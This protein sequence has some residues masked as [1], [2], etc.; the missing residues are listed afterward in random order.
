MKLIDK[1]FIISNNKSIIVQNEH[2]IMINLNHPFIVNLE[3]S[4]ESK[5]YIV[6]ILEFCS[7]GELFYHLRKFKRLKESQARFY[8]MEMCLGLLYLHSK[9]VIYRDIKPENILLD[10]NGHIRIA[11]FGLSKPKKKLE[12]PSHSF[13]GSPEYMAPEMLQR[14]G[15]NQQVDHYCLG[16]LLYELVVGLPPFYSQNPEEIYHNILTKEVTYP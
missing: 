5:H 9:G 4:F 1:K 16:A 12:S 14:N 8:I 7:G 11:D 2:D 13:C 10:I 15:H 3:F 6:F